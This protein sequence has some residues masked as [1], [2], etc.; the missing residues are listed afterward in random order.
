MTLFNGSA[1][2]QLRAEG[3]AAIPEG[4]SVSIRRAIPLDKWRVRGAYTVSS[5]TKTDIVIE[6]AGVEI[7]SALLADA[8]HLLDHAAEH[9]ATLKHWNSQGDWHSPG[10]SLVTVYYWAFFLALALT[11]LVGSTTWFLNRESITNLRLLAGGAAQPGA[12]CLRF[13]LGPFISATDRQVTLRQNKAHLHEAVWRNVFELFGRMML[14][15]NPTAHPEEHQLLGALRETARRLTAAWPS[16][17]RNAVNYLPGCGYKEVLKETDINL[18]QFLRKQ[19]PMNSGEILAQVSGHLARIAPGTLT[20]DGI[21]LFCRCL[22]LLTLVLSETATNLHAELIE[23][24][25]LDPRWLQLRSGFLKANGIA[26]NG[27][28]WPFAS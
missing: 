9:H 20:T 6:T 28:I 5:C 22:L 15:S 3:L 1:W 4:A 14:A 24:N 13:E 27:E 11:R 8:E 12:G 19:F 23:R 10:W 26:V 18:G 7:G 2:Q 17:L 21:P 25:S 16:D